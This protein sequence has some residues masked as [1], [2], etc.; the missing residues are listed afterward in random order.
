QDDVEA[1]GR[2]SAPDNI[3]SFSAVAYFFGGNLQ[4][5]LGVP[6]GLIQTAW[7]GTRAE[8][9]TSPETMAEVEE[10]KPILDAWAQRVENY[11]PD[12]AKAR[13]ERVLEKWRDDVAAARETGHPA[14]RRPQMVEDPQLDRHHPSN[15]YNGMIAPL[16]PFA[17][18]G[19]I[20][21]QG[22]SNANRAYQ[23]RTLMPAM[24]QRWRD[25]WGQG[26]FPFYQVQLANFDPAW[27]REKHLPGDSSWAELREAQFLTTQ[28]LPNVG[29][30]CITDIG[31]AKDI[32]PK[33]KQD[34]GKRLARLAL[35]DV[36]GMGDK[37]V[38]NGP[39]Y[40][41][42]SVESNKVTLTFEV[43]NSRIIPSYN[44]ELTDFAIA[45]ED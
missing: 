2:V 39:V 6:V 18:R 26:D 22:E 41:S 20:W 33:N 19:A 29:A 31:A 17:M 4:E 14:P 21:Y 30:A 11:D 38:R 16:V 7:G 3:S 9:W 15:L 27:S 25:A 43:G 40:K 13:N 35:V 34:V 5:T 8:A 1:S 36:Y 44:E 42:M 10:L 28:A 24:I 12:A 32:H 45:G 37:L 23:Y